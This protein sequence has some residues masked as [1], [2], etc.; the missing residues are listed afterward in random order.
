MARVGSA[1]YMGL[2]SSSSSRGAAAYFVKPMYGTFPKN[3]ELLS[4]LRA[5]LGYIAISNQAGDQK[6]F[7]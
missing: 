7:L 6:T 5:L 1:P 4:L 2:K 3:L